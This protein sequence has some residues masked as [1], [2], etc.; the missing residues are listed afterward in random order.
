MAD[1]E[2]YS[3]G[4][5]LQESSDVV[6][7]NDG[8]AYTLTFKNCPLSRTGEI[9]FRCDKGRASSKAQL[10]VQPTAVEF[11]C[12]LED[13]E[14][15]EKEA[16]EFTVKLSKPV[17]FV[18]WT[19]NANKLK[20]GGNVSMKSDK[21]NTDHTL[22]L[23]EVTMDMAGELAV[24][25][26]GAISK[27]QMSVTRDLKFSGKMKDVNCTEGEEAKLETSL[28]QDAD[29]EWFKNGQPIEN[30]EPRVEGRKRFLVIAEAKI[31]DAGE[32]T[33][34]VG[35]KTTSAQ[36]YVDLA[37]VR[38]TKQLMD[39]GAQEGNEGIF[40]CT[41][42]RDE[43][44]T[45][46]K[47]GKEK[48]SAGPKY[49]ME[50]DG[51]VRRLKIADISFSDEAKFTCQ[52]GDDKTTASM[53]VQTVA[54]EFVGA[55]K[56]VTVQEGE[57]AEFNIELNLPDIKPIQWFQNGIEQTA[58]AG[59][60]IISDGTKHSF[61]IVS[62]TTMD[63]AEIM[64]NAAGTRC[65]AQLT[66]AQTPL[67]FV[68]ALQ[69]C[70]AE[71]KLANFDLEC[72]LNRANANVKWLRN[73]SEIF[74]S[75]KYA[76]NADGAKRILTISDVCKDDEAEYVCSAEEQT[77]T[78]NLKIIP[79]NIKFMSGLEDGFGYERTTHT[80]EVEISHVNMDVEWFL[81]DKKIE[82]SK[83]VEFDAKGTAY[84]LTINDLSLED[85]G[86]MKFV[87][88]GQETSCNFEVRETPAKFVKRLQDECSTEKEECILSCELNRSNVDVVWKHNGQEVTA[89][90]RV[91]LL[92]DNRRRALVIKSVEQTDEGDYSCDAKDDETT[93]S[94]VIGGRDIRFT[95]K[96]Q[97]KEVLEGEKAVFELQ[98][99]H[100]EVEG[101][102]FVNGDEVRNSDDVE[103][104]VEGR[105]HILT[106]EN[107]VAKQTG[108]VIFKIT[109]GPKCEARLDVVEAPA[110]FTA[111]I[112]D[113]TVLENEN[114]VFE[115]KV[116]KGNAEVQWYKGR[117]KLHLSDKYEM[118]AVEFNRSLIVKNCS[119]DDE[120][121]F[122]AQV[123][124]NKCA[125]KLNIT[126]KVIKLDDVYGDV[127][128]TVGET[129]EFTVRASELGEDA[130]W[131]I[132]GIQMK[133]DD[134]IELW[135]DGLL[136]GMRIKS[137]AID[138]TGDITVSILNAKHTAQL[139][140]TDGPACFVTK[141]EDKGV[142]DKAKS[143][144]LVC[145]LNRANAQVKWLRDG[146][147]IT[148]SRK[149]DMI[150]R[151]TTCTLVIADITKE[152][153]AL[154]VCDCGDE[155]T[156]SQVSVLDQN[157]SLNAPFPQEKVVI[158]RDTLDIEVEISHEN[159]E[160]S[161]ELVREGKPN[162]ILVPS[163][164]VEMNTFRTVHSLKIFNCELDL[165]GD[166]IFRAG[167][168]EATCKVTVKEPG[169]RFTK[170]LADQCATECDACMFECEISRA[171][172][173]VTWYLNDQ[174]VEESDKFVI[175]SKGRVRIL[176]VNDC[177]SADEGNVKCASED[178]ETIA[179]LQISG[180]D[181]KI[182]KKLSDMEVTEGESVTFEL[183]VNYPD[184][185]GKWA[186]N[187]QAI[188]HGDDYDMSVKGK[189]QILKINSATAEMAGVISWSSGNAKGT[190]NLSVL[191][192]PAQFITP[193]EDMTV[194]EKSQC[195][196][197]CEVNRANVRTRWLKDRRIPI[198]VSDK[199][200]IVEREKIRSLIIKDITYDDEGVYT[201][202]ADTAKSNMNLTVC[203]RDIKLTAPMRDNTAAE[204]GTGLM[205]FDLSHNEVSTTWLRNGQK[206]AKS[207]LIDMTCEKVET[208]FR[209]TL[210]IKEIG[211]DDG[212][213][214][215]FNAEGIQGEATLSICANP[216]DLLQELK[217]TVCR[218]GDN[219]SFQTKVSDPLASG[220]WFINGV[221]LNRSDRMA[222]ANDNGVHTLKV[223][224]ATTDE[225]GEIVFICNNAR[226][227]ADVIVKE[228]KVTFSQKLA[229]QNVTEK[230]I[231]EFET[232]VNRINA[233][234]EWVDAAGNVIQEGGRFEFVQEGRKRRL[235]IEGVLMGDMGQIRCR[236]APE[237]EP[238][239]F[240]AKLR[241][242]QTNESGEAIFDCDV[243]QPSQSV[244]WFFD[245]Q[246]LSESSK[247]QMV[248]DK[249]RKS[250]IVKNCSAADM[251]FY[252]CE[253]SNC[254][255]S[256][257]ELTVADGAKP[258]SIRQ[259]YVPDVDTEKPNEV[260]ARLNV[261]ARE[262][263]IRRHLQDQE[264]FEGEGV[265]FCCETSISDVTPHW[266][267]NGVLLK[268]D[269]ETVIFKQEGARN[270]LIL[271]ECQGTQSGAVEFYG[272]TKAHLHVIE[273][274]VD[275]TEEMEPV[276][277]FEKEMAKFH[278][279][280]S[281]A[282]AKVKWFK[283]R[284]LLKEG[285]ARY[286]MIE[287]GCNRFLII[288]KSEFND[289]KDYTC[290][291]D[292]AVVTTKLTVNP[293]DI[294]MVRPL[295]D[296]TVN[297]KQDA[298]FECEL[299]HDE[300]DVAWFRDG[301][302]VI[303]SGQVIMEME[304]RIARLILKNVN[305][306]DD[307]QCDFMLRAEDSSTSAILTVKPSV[308]EILEPLEE[309]YICAEGNEYTFQ[310]R[311]SQPA[312]MGE[313]YMN[314]NQ[315]RR[316]HDID[317]KPAKGDIHKI[318]FK[319]VHKGMTGNLKFRLA[320]NGA[321]CQ[322]N[323]KIKGPAVNFA[324]KLPEEV[325]GNEGVPMVFEVKLDRKPDPEIACWKKDGVAIDPYDPKYKLEERDDGKTQR[326][327]V[328]K[329]T[330]ED[331]GHYSYDTGD[332]ES[333][334]KALVK[335][336]H[337]KIFYFYFSIRDNR[338]YAA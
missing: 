307:D 228:P 49:T 35:D 11:L 336:E 98:L 222:I 289:E 120:A 282:N 140:V 45:W 70:E 75:R 258:N 211:L 142:E 277:V 64:F 274:P 194:E 217:R 156:Q 298:V 90:D 259:P 3:N 133:E 123:G 286:E 132:N 27:C 213:V 40:E 250:L 82:E 314:G 86:K 179:E 36:L 130:K 237:F 329:P 151:K 276:V 69:D 316:T 219:I 24:N 167:N 279:K 80:F 235:V 137:C 159:V 30:G 31:E 119:F 306:E 333:V 240:A 291:C 315:V 161:W 186:I 223:K 50:D 62:P 184:I 292:D 232:E 275:F 246:K 155:Q 247:Y 273:Q 175:E 78:S 139:T 198:Q 128:K 1:Y 16:A 301:A 287:D 41:I 6:M 54:I 97:D 177:Q 297:E 138:M 196:M 332:D 337:T 165:T 195:V 322:A 324:S 242:V 65:S 56:D 53:A 221:K 166:L 8:E 48:L 2:W 121:Q 311:V 71:N 264:C 107:C 168:L 252:K 39:T 129:V 131:M 270:K 134:N 210:V 88:E 87:C 110:A 32:Y 262:I 248:N 176:T 328:L 319:R 150:K 109:D 164:S 203:A 283:G 209:Y 261:R 231:V 112:T 163:K 108:P 193:L 278:A 173:E 225:A 162:E 113:I 320:K 327:V 154:Y 260:S 199:Y 13:Q 212:G 335:G 174:K 84:L 63:T 183:D 74:P 288:K 230:A 296:I 251:G 334:C 118:V 202:D 160:S 14:V 22:Y 281:R 304:G 117:T 182:L 310:V 34:K 135:V 305:Q 243:N 19:L 325:M 338:A 214:I 141:L 17:K 204:K 233:A 206:L 26:E 47:N 148:P 94:L 302:K 58:R 239:D 21:T 309:K 313:W 37:P 256:E 93:C 12:P 15:G 114:A 172:A 83:N 269:G 152:D 300:V 224:N 23:D 89:S 290:S 81:N 207:R 244:E 147:E 92:V 317:I 33:C 330:P 254:K 253:L 76:M 46:F 266:T 245:G 122:S 149:F 331:A 201:C 236:G 181:I 265:E 115:C 321:Q 185:K 144:E 10:T 178:D 61:V 101:V 326:L 215:T 20:S 180:R 271:K 218:Q 52:V 145:E 205:S 77:T 91:E 284:R 102:W 153:G 308:L 9:E 116:S 18:E 124:D 169:A 257:A 208:G 7:T 59:V 136:Y 170:R 85:A 190:S 171:N 42:S 104:K 191:E 188:A 4:D 192:A 197:E 72:E 43:P 99:S 158:E 106:L 57:R 66:V 227:A 263:K 303:K 294:K 51:M 143:L 60:E 29:V 38:F 226:S 125:A 28:S 220:Q 295:E 103:I 105:K 241:D 67:K 96:M 25:A 111:P 79:A 200:E 5:K 95:K 323:L 238:L 127:A 249:F 126:S 100:D 312:A 229:D 189:K 187:D 55:I 267:I 285:G 268:E 299:S 44:V 272:K 234:V 293:R 280:V 255:T 68:K 73:G 318:H 146:A 216:V 157:I